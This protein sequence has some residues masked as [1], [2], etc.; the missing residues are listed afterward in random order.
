M[1]YWRPSLGWALSICVIACAAVQ[2]DDLPTTKE[3]DPQPTLV[4]LHVSNASLSDIASKIAAQTGMPVA[5]GFGNSAMPLSLDADQQPFWKVMDDLCA[6]SNSSIIPT[7]NNTQQLTLMPGTRPPLQRIISGPAMLEFTGVQHLSQLTVSKDRQDF[8]ELTG[9]AM[10][11]P[12]LKVLFSDAWT[13]PTVA[14]DE[15]GLSLVP[16]EKTA[17]SDPRANPYQQNNTGQFSVRDRFNN[18]NL[19]S[20]ELHVR[21]HVPPG[22]GRTIKTLSGQ[23]RFFVAR[24]MDHFDV[25][26]N[27]TAKS[28]TTYPLGD[29]A[30]LTLQYSQANEDTVQMSFTIPSGTDGQLPPNA[31]MAKRNSL[32][33]SLQARVTDADGNTW[34]DT[35]GD[36]NGGQV[37]VGMGGNMLYLQIFIRRSASGKGKPAK[38]TIEAPVSA[39]EIDAS[40]SLHDLPLP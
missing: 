10:W 11:E 9:Q 39:T 38:I 3:N 16:D 33:Q 28:R 23:W 14:V 6:R 8:C 12:R 13:V 18:M 5:A 35:N 26:A 32:L 36:F 2:A 27:A 25:P 17:A 4:T 19:Y 15:N 20:R 29:L 34:G 31:E 1:I 22:A 24:K 30:S 40:F 21:L 37:N 7:W